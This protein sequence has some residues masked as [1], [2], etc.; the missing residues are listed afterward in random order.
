MLTQRGGV[1]MTD[2]WKGEHLIR[3]KPGQAE[4]RVEASRV[5]AAAQKRKKD[6][7]AKTMR[8]KRAKK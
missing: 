8:E 7:K 5:M 6:A 1:Q 2:D 3:A 4:R